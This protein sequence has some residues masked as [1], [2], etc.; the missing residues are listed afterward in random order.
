MKWKLYKCC[1]WLYCCL[2]AWNITKI[3][4][5]SASTPYLLYSEPKQHNACV[6]SWRICNVR[7]RYSELLSGHASDSKES[8]HWAPVL[9]RN[10]FSIPIPTIWFLSLFLTHS[11]TQT[12]IF[13]FI[14]FLRKKLTFYLCNI[15]ITSVYDTHLIVSE[16]QY[17]QTEGPSLNFKREMSSKVPHLWAL[18]LLVNGQFT[19]SDVTMFLGV[20]GYQFLKMYWNKL[21]LWMITS[22]IS[23]SPSLFSLQ[24]CLLAHKNEKSWNKNKCFRVHW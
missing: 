12:L 11:S 1:K 21:S 7:N 17:W 4:S 16:V 22:R 6:T 13:V 23:C 2:F 14:F 8:T 9:K 15:L 3:L 10:R 24:A 5:A 19:K 20:W 18:H